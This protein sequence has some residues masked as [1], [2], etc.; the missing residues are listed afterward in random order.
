MNNLWQQYLWKSYLI[1]HLLDDFSSKDNHDGIHLVL[2]ICNA[3]IAGVLYLRVSLQ[4]VTPALPWILEILPG[5][6]SKVINKYEV[7]HLL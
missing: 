7:T 2:A 3:C 5:R 1:E 6:R 4:T